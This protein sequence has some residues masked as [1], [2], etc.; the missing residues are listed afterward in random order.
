MTGSGGASSNPSCHWQISDA[1]DYLIR[2]I[3]PGDDD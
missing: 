3:K 1:S 2:P